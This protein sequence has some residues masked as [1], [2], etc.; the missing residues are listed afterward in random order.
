LPVELL[1]VVQA[2]L[3]GATGERRDGERRSSKRKPRAA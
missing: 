2:V 3:P 1:E